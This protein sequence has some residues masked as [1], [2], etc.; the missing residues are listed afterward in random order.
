LIIILFFMNCNYLLALATA[1]ALA[2]LVALALALATARST[3][4]L[5]PALQ[6]TLHCSG[7]LLYSSIYGDLYSLVYF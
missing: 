7:D 2:S 3:A 4:T 1:L 6:F 5:L